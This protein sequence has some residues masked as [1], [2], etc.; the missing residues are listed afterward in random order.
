MIFVCSFVVVTPSQ[1]EPM[2]YAPQFVPSQRM[3]VEFVAP[4]GTVMAQMNLEIPSVLYLGS[5]SWYVEAQLP[6]ASPTAAPLFPVVNRLFSAESMRALFQVFWF[7]TP[8]ECVPLLN[9]PGLAMYS[10][11]N[12]PSPGVASGPR[13]SG[14]L[15]TPVDLL[16]IVL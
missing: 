13:T 10:P 12:V 4:L 3:L 6:A 9:C 11:K 5:L 14:R 16:P 7:H 15:S 8:P 1:P 2:P